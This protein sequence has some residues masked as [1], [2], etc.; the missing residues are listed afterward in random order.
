[1]RSS[2]NVGVVILLALATVAAVL[3][4]NDPERG[5]GLDAEVIAIS[6]DTPEDA[7]KTVGERGL[8]FPVVPD[9]ARAI[10]ETYG[11]A[12]RGKMNI[13]WPSVVVVDKQGRVEM[14]FAD[15]QGRRLHFADLQ[16]LLRKLSG[17]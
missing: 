1:M 9:A 7:E 2:L 13:A 16:P 4:M 15:P 6:A 17:T 10:I 11:V 12:N 8:A 5:V 14:A 3:S